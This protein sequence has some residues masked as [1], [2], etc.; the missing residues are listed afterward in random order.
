M[1]EIMHKVFWDR[2]EAQLNEDPPSYEH[3]IKLL[4]EIKEVRID[5]IKDTL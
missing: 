5:Q 3:A 1:K 2:L 4:G